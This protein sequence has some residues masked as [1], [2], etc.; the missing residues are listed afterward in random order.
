MNKFTQLKTFTILKALILSVT[1]M[2]I[3]GTVSAGDKQA[4][5]DSHEDD[6][7]AGEVVTMSDETALQNG[8][9]TA[10]VIAGDISLSTTLYGRISADPG[11]LSHIRAR[12]DGVIKDVK[13][14]IGDTVKKGDV[15]AVVESNKSLKSYSI[16]SPFE[17]NVIARHANNGELSNGQVLFSLANYKNVWAQLT[18]F[19]QHLS[20]IKV[21][22][23]VEL[24]HANFEQLSEI[25]YLTPSADGSPHSL[26]NVTVDN[27]SGYWPLGT[28]V[29]AQVTTT[30][31]AVSHMVPVTAVQE[32]EDKQVVFV[33][34][35]NEYKPRPV[36]LGVTDGRFIE[37]I[38]GIELGELVVVTNSYLIKADLEKSEAGHDH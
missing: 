29:K 24:R 8:I 36:Q 28:L 20:K 1:L 32:Y 3:H 10:N 17:G 37:V 15:L 35:D 2:M 21:G 23:A 7:H 22:Q 30:T 16:V 26:A 13:V 34:Y 12:F 18:V 14:N 33:S 27:S 5:G 19:S 38:S 9:T 11:S 25:A 6:K 31:K 4:G